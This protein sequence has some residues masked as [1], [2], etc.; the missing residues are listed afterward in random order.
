MELA[1][2]LQSASARLAISSLLIAAWRLTPLTL[3][4]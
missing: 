4:N 2:R 3:P 1:N